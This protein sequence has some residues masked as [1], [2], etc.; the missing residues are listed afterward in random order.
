MPA[1]KS[2]IDRIAVGKQMDLDE[3]S[4]AFIPWPL[5]SFNKFC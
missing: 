5:F 1:K 4:C 2:E 3:V